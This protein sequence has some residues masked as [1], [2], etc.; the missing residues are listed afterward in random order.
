MKWLWLFNQFLLDQK[1]KR[2]EARVHNILASLPPDDYRLLDD[3]VLVTDR[4]TTQI[5]HV[6]VSRF[7]LFVIETK[8]YRG[9]IYG[10]DN[11]KEWTQIIPTKVTYRIWK[12]YTYI[13]KSK[14]YNPVKQTLIHLYEL[15]KNLVDFPDLKFF[16]IVVF[17]GNANLSHVESNCHVVYASDLIATIKSH[18]YDIISDEDA[19]VIAQRL[20]TR[21]VRKEVTNSK[22]VQNIRKSAADV[23]RKVHEGIC[24]RCGGNLVKRTGAY[25]SFWGCS[26]Y[27]NCKYTTH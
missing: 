10:N 21:N 27:P 6:V 16:P 23:K 14:F 9:E 12:T 1:G 2:G 13:T 4:G 8:N 22:H 25:G 24:P 26:N 20:A 19:E 5:D 11:Q 7:G 18:R 15:K 17:V 3:V